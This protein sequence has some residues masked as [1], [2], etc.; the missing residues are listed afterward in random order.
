MKLRYL[1]VDPCGQLRRVSGA[2][3]QELWEGRVRADA[4]GCTV[5][6]ELRLVSVLCDRRLLPQRIFLLRMALTDGYFTRHNFRALRSFTMPSR[7]TALRGSKVA[8]APVS[9]SNTTSGTPGVTRASTSS[10][11]VTACTW[12]SWPARAYASALET[13]GSSSISST[14]GMRRC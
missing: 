10:A 12:T 3:V 13:R 1:V 11:S 14:R 5:G 9:R 7:V 8:S 2:T 6:N 4:F